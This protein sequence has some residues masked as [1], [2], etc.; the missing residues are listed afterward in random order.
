MYRGPLIEPISIELLQDTDFDIEKF[1]AQ[2][3]ARRY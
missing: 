3:M 1:V 2:E